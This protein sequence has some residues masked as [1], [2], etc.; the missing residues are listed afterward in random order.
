M[1]LASMARDEPGS[2]ALFI[3][4]LDNLKTINDTFGHPAGDGL[5]SAA[6]ERI[7][8]AMLPDIT[9]RL[10]GDEVAVLVQYPEALT[11]LARSDEYTSELLSLMRTSYAGV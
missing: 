4:D 6:G 10:G 3:V 2:W 11:D 5:I 8:A 9:F 1:A 7:A